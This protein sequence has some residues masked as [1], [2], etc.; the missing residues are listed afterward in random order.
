MSAAAAKERARELVSALLTGTFERDRAPSKKLREA[1]DEYLKWADANRAASADDRRDHANAIVASVG[2]VAL[3]AI[4]RSTSNAS[5]PSGP[6]R[7]ARPARS[8]AT[9]PR[10]STSSGSRAIGV[11]PA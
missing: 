8:I 5:R 2:D 6:R 7:P 9:S 11:D 10:S 1:F 4:T 3:D